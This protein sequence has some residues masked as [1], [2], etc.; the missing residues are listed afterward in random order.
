M[1]P[2]DRADVV[3]L[4]RDRVA[5]SETAEAPSQ[6]PHND[7]L[8]SEVVPPDLYQRLLWTLFAPRADDEAA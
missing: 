6:T 4:N 3:P 1:D 2:Q 7:W 5:N 8:V